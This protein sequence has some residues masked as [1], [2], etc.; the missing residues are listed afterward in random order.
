MVDLLG[1]ELE[2]NE[3]VKKV[4]DPSQSQL[5]KV[6]G[7]SE[8]SALCVTYSPIGAGQ[9]KFWNITPSGDGEIELVDLFPDNTLEPQAPSS[10][11]WTLADFSVVLDKTN[12]N[13]FI[14][15]ALWK[16]NVT[17]R[18]QKLDFQSGSISRVRDAW[19]GGWTAMATET[20]RETPLPSVFSGDSSDGTDKWLDF[21]LSPGRFTDA[22]VETGLAIYSRGLGGKES[23]RRSGSLPERMCSTISST[24]SLT[25]TSDGGMDYDQF[26]TA[27]DAQWRRFYR[28]LQELDK[29][30]GE[31]MSLVIDPQ[32]EMPWVILA[33]G[34]TAIRDCSGLERI[35]H[36]NGIVP[37]ATEHVAR[38]LFAAASFRDSLPDQF[39]YSCKSMLLEEL[40]QEP[41]LTNPARMRLFYDKC[42]FSNQIGEEEYS[43]LVSGLGGNFKDITTQV[44]EAILG[45]MLASEDFDKRSQDQPLA[46]FGNKL[47]VK[48]VQETVELH[49]N[50]CLDQL[51]LLILIEAEINHT[52]EGIQFETAAVFSQLVT[53]LKRLE[54]INWLS[55][56]QI[57]LP[58]LKKPERPNSV[59]EKSSGL[60]K[61][62]P[63]M[64][65]ITVLEGVLRHLFSLDLRQGETMS[66]VVTEVI[67]QICAPNSEYESPP[68]VIQCFLLKQERA[69]LAVEFSRFA[70]QDPFSTY[71]QGR[72]C[73]ATNDALTASLLFKKAAFGLGMFTK[74]NDDEY[75]TNRGTAH[76][77]PRKPA[78]HHSAGYLEAT[79][80]NLLNAGLPEYYSHIVALFDKEKIYSFVIDFARLS[81]QFIKTSDVKAS[82]LRTEMDSR[83][84][85]AAIQTSRYEI[86]DSILSLFTDSALQHSSLRTLVTKMCESSRAAQLTEL[87][88][89][90]LQ[91]EVDEILAQKCQGIVDVTVGVPYHKILYAWRIKRNDFRGAAAICLERLQ[92]LQ[93]SGDGDK[94]LGDDGLETPVTKQYVMLINALSCVDPK[95]AWILAEELPKKGNKGDNLKRKVV[96]LDDIR[97]GY[98]EE[99]DR[100]AAIQNG[101]FAFAGG[102]EMD[103]L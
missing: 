23:T 30:R 17:Y 73:L 45:I 54:L 3:E 29:Q 90:G 97:R 96:T 15:W 85:N 24:A 103:V 50:V 38:P 48:G 68:A 79:E 6:V 51:I 40:F 43:Q 33:D 4:I 64:E 19:N 36:N 65:T 95:Q 21:I 14:L 74:V 70:A 98:Q 88:F 61:K 101:Q 75:N 80:R 12:I 60:I 102:D 86:A 77:N 93:Q 87:P 53:M 20:L 8:E 91:D 7:D 27:I 69:D 56:T 81:L 89:I 76:P 41:S 84:F 31:A 72:A 59:T 62:P 13:S 26:R 34:I 71:I 39:L 10:E 66:T 16:N 52:E 18:L 63:R 9:F 83:L 57:S 58:L 42:D 78:D 100:L 37:L 99:L 67:L 5:I 25:R 55:N 44:Y 49:R 2:T 28:L 32:G 46:E 35:W 94:I 1:Q 92:K 82:N 47:L 22:T 11:I